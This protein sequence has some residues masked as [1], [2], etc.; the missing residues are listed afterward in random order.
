MAARP[1]ILDE[2][3]SLGV[4]HLEF[5]A[6]LPDP[7]FSVWLGTRTDDERNRIGVDLVDPLELP[8]QS[9]RLMP[10]RATEAV[11]GLVTDALQAA[12]FDRDGLR[13]VTVMVQ[14]QETV[15]RD[16]ESSWF[17]ALR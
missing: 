15:D 1:L 10:K 6:A 3:R 8:A 16:C 12:G 9:R 13:H 7:R 4:E 5:I 2:T 14:S 11:A 17:H